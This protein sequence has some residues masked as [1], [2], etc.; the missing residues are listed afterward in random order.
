[1]ARVYVL[2]ENPTWFVPLGAALDRQG[3]PYEEWFIDTGTIGLDLPPPEGVFFNRLSGSAHTRGHRLAVEHARVVLRWLE[4]HG[5]RVVNRLDAL[6]L[7]MSK[8]ALLS[9]LAAAGIRTPRT[10]VAVGTERLVGA[11]ASFSQP[12]LIKPNRSGKGIGIRYVEAGSRLDAALAAE[13]ATQ[14]IDGIWLLQEYV[15]PADGFIDR[16]EFVGGEL[17]YALR[18]D[19]QSG[20]NLCPAD[21]CPIPAAGRAGPRFSIRRDFTHPLVG[22]YRKFL[23]NHGVE[24]AAIEFLTDRHGVAYTYDLNINT[25]YNA[26][27][28]A[29]AGL[30]G[31]QAIAGFLGAELDR[32][33]APAIPPRR[34]GAAE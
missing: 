3:V 16:L 15:P 30:S 24:V 18:A 29:A 21:D 11:A 10:V 13:L 6:E 2:H 33:A 8:S 12:F 17:L 19:A 9:A 32:L 25:N 1:M 31:M 5:R 26:G 20:F 28:E 23:R 27:A 7:A 14:S 34:A 22:L 4:R